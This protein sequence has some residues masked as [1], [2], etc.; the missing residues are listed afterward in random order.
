MNIKITHNWLLEYLDTKATP[1]QIQKYLSLCGPSVESVTKI[2]DDVI[3]DIEVTSNRIDSASVIGIAREAATILTR[4]GI[5]ST[6]KSPQVKKP[7]P[8]SQGLPFEI[9]D[10]SRLCRRLLAIVMDNVVIKPSPKYIQDRLQATGIRSLNNV[11]DITNYVMMEIGHPC[12][13]F[14]YDRIKLHKFIIRKAKEKEEII[15]LDDKKYLLCGDDIII[16]DGTDAVIDFPGIMGTANS[17]VTPDTKR[18]IFFIES[19]DPVAIRKSSMKYG[20]RTVA[21]TMNEKN[22]DPEIAKLTFLRG[23]ELFQQLAGAK[24]ASNIFDIYQNQQKTKTLNFQYSIFDKLIGV[25][26]DTKEINTILQNLGFTIDNNSHDRGEICNLKV[27]SWRYNDINIPE[28]LVEEVARIHGYFNLPN[29]MPPMAYVKRSK[30][31]EDLFVM[32]NKVKLLLKHLGLNEVLNYSMIS[33]KMVKDLGFKIKDHLKLS[34]TLSED[35]KYLRINLV[36]SL[37]KNIHDN[38][39]RKETLRLFELAK[40]YPKRVKDL[41]DE[42]LKLAIAVNTSFEDLK[43][44]VE[45]IFKELN[46]KSI[47]YRVS[48]IEYFNTKI[49]AE[50]VSSQSSLPAG[51]QTRNDIG[52]MGQVKQQY[53]LNFEIKDD[54]FVAEL[55]FQTLINDAKSF[56]TYKPLS[57][58][59]V[60]KL[61]LTIEQNPK[62]TYV[63]IQKK[64]FKT[65]K[66]LINLEL[67]SIYKNKLSL[68]F[69]FSSPDRNITEEEAKEELKRV[70]TL[71]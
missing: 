44:I 13:V 47:E 28:D 46:I 14:D 32:Q 68:R 17:V 7:Q 24:P 55:D 9:Q 71:L 10:S 50:I 36:T 56:P 1:E 60:I 3:Y 62:I 29:N 16:D 45:A 20:I 61:D 4:F 53:A 49:Q 65:S 37:L 63:E 41:P 33:E 21:A 25:K 69:Y 30:P 27:P 48:S 6:F 31:M 15:T 34:N 2:N 22:P 26:I 23:I 19:N 58:Y 70:E 59:S 42:K 66:L 11:V 43:G 64:A 52:F 38:Q 54:V 57:P 12:H 40:V 8:L 51:R 35:I 18:I 39:D 67:V 5:K